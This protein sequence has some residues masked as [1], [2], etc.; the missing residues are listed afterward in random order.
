MTMKVIDPVCGMQIDREE[1][2]ATESFHG[3]PFY[4]CSGSCRDK[5]RANPERYADKESDKSPGSHHE[6]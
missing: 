4:F 2:A 5:F 1:A 6:R 3:R